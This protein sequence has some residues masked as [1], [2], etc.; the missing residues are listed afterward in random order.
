MGCHRR[1]GRGVTFGPNIP[2]HRAHRHGQWLPIAL[3]CEAASTVQCSGGVTMHSR[4]PSAAAA[5]RLENC[6]AVAVL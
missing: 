4:Q 6:P 5:E 2:P 3:A 1:H